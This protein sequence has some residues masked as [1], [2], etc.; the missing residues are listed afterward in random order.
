MKT[1]ERAHAHEWETSTTVGII[2]LSV[3]PDSERAEPL[4]QSLVQLILDHVQSRGLW[5]GVVDHTRT[6][7]NKGRG[8]TF[9]HEGRHVPARRREANR[10]R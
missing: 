6:P 3:W 5:V 2:R 4:F 8:E 10:P 9:V 7:S 1:V